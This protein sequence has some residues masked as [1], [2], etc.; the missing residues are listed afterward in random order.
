MKSSIKSEKKNSELLQSLAKKANLQKQK[1][2]YF[3]FSVVSLIA[4]IVFAWLKI[5][6]KWISGSIAIFVFAVMNYYQISSPPAVQVSS[7]SQSSNVRTEHLNTSSTSN[8]SIYAQRGNE[9]SGD[10]SRILKTS[11]ST[12]SIPSLPRDSH[13]H[14]ATGKALSPL[15]AN[16]RLPSLTQPAATS[17]LLRSPELSHRDGYDLS[18]AK[19]IASEAVGS[20]TKPHAAQNMPQQSL[21]S[22]N[23]PYGNMAH[24]S[25][26]YRSPLLSTPIGASSNNFYPPREYQISPLNTKPVQ[27]NAVQQKDALQALGLTQIPDEWIDELRLILGKHLHLIMEM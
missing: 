11:T 3:N 16:K 17:P 19:K 9:T 2:Y 10:S 8:T 4:I 1:S 26:S 14:G 12:R 6:W 7:S 24:I 27:S 18:F 15:L 23:S 25:S 13:L 22:P 5:D 21:F 20:H